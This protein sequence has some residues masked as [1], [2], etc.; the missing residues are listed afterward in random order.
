MNKNMHVCSCVHM[1]V[2]VHVCTCVCA[3]ACV[4]MRVPHKKIITQFYTL[5]LQGERV[6]HGLPLALLLQ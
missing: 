4:Y 1:C 3:C 5:S 2:H 6:L